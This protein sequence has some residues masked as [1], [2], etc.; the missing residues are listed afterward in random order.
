MN[1]K[2]ID[3]INGKLTFKNWLVIGVIVLAVVLGGMGDVLFNGRII[4]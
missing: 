1:Q 2:D 4:N 3:K